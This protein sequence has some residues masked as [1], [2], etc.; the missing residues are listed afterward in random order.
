MKIL[1]THLKDCFVVEPVVFED[2]RGWFMETFSNEIL[3]QHGLEFD[4]IQD[5]H[6]FSKDEGILRG[7]HFQVNPKAQTKLVRCIRG[8][9]LDV[10]I[11]LRKGSPSFLQYIAIE[12][13]SENKKQI[14]IP[15]GFAHGFLTLSDNCEVVYK[16]DENYSKECDRSVRYDD[17]VLNINW[18]SINFI[19]SEKDIHATNFEQININFVYE[20]KEK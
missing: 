16:V 19:M 3:K 8:R 13:S 5:N 18:P 1:S 7:L 14:L 4:F 11:D 10:A 6:S 20:E 15:K 9:I 12:L 2:S 17:P